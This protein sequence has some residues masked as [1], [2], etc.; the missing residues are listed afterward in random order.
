[1]L[2]AIRPLFSRLGRDDDAM[3]MLL[4]M[5]SGML[6]GWGIAA[7]CDAA[8]LTG[9]QM[10]PSIAGFCTLLAFM[11]FGSLQILIVKVL[12]VATFCH[13][14]LLKCSCE[15]SCDSKI[16][17]Y[18]LFQHPHN[19]SFPYSSWHAREY[20]KPGIVIDLI[21]PPCWFGHSDAEDQ[22]CYV[23]R[24]NDWWHSGLCFFVKPGEEFWI[25]GRLWF[26]PTEQISSYCSRLHDHKIYAQQTQLL[27]CR[28]R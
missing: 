10:Y 24:L 12:Q 17:H 6:I 4:E 1:M 5:L 18:L 19:D 28:F 21:Y 26:V 27:R 20:C 9:T 11:Y 8:Y 16:M 25:N 7:Q 14:I 15:I 3:P 2:E 13:M 23:L 22:S